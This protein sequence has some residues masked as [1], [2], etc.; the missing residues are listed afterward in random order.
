[1]LLLSMLVAAPRA[2]RAETV[3]SKAAASYRVLVFSK[4]AGE[5]VDS[6]PAGIAAIREL[7][8]QNDFAVDTTEDSG[9]FTEENLAQ[10]KAVV[11]LSV[12]GDVLNDDQQQA[13][14]GFVE[15]GGGLVA[16]NTA[17]DAE[18]DWEWYGATIGARTKSSRPA[19]Q[20]GE[21]L[22]YDPAHPSTKDLPRRVKH[23]D[24]FYNYTANVRGSLHVL[25]GVDEKSYSPGDGA[26]GYD[27]PISWCGEVRQGR[28]WYSGLGTVASAYEDAEFRKHLLG[29]IQTAAGVIES[30][31]GATVWKNF[32]TTL[33]TKDVGE[34]MDLAVL[35]DGRVLMTSRRGEFRLFDQRTGEVTMAATIDVYTGEE[36]GLQGVELDPN[37]KEN[38]W[39]YF[40][41]SPAGTTPENVLSRAKLVGDK[42]DLST[43]QK[44]LHVPTQRRLCCHVGGDIGFDAE[45][46][47]YLST[48]DNINPWQSN[49]YAPIDERPGRGDYDDQGHAANTN[50]LRGKILRIKVNEDGS[51]SIPEGNLFP[52]GTEKTKPEIYTMGER[53]PFRFDVDKKTGW[54][55][56]G[57]VGPD[58]N[59]DSPTQ[60]PEAFERLNQIRGPENHGWPYCQ[61]N[62]KP[63][64]DYDF[65]T[66]TT[67][68]PFDCDNLVNDSPNNTGLRNLPPMTS[69]LLWYPNDCATW[70]EFPQFCPPTP[71]GR[72]AMGAPVYHYDE[73][74][75]SDTKFPAY[76]DGTPFFYDYSRHR[77][78]DIKL[79][80]EGDLLNIN[81]FLPNMF[82]S[83]DGSVNGQPMDMEF[84]PDGSLYFLDYGGGF[85]TVGPRVGLYRVDY[86]KGKRSP[87]IQATATPTSGS[88]PLTV[89]FDASGTHDPD[90]DQIS[91]A[92]DFDGDGTTDSSEPV[93]EH[94]YTAKGA[95]QARLLVSDVTGKSSVQTFP[96]T[97][98]NNAPKVTISFPG[99]GGFAAFGET[100]P[101]KINVTDAED[102]EI[103]CDAVELQVAL[104]HDQHAHPILEKNGCEGTFAL[105]NVEGH[106][107]DANVFTVLRAIYTDK[108]ADGV[109]GLEG[110]HQ[111]LLQPKRKQAEHF[112]ENNGTAVI[113]H[114][115]A[116]GGRRIGAIH[117]GDWLAFNPVDLTNMTSAT[118]RVSSGGAGGTIE[119][120]K[121]SP[122][123]PLAGTA[124]VDNTGSYD[125]YVT[126][127]PVPL[128]DPGGGAD[129]LFLVFTN[130]DSSD[131]LFDVDSVRFNGK[132]MAE[133]I[134]VQVTANEKSGPAPLTVTF[135]ATAPDAPANAVYTWDFGDGG[136][137]QGA[138]VTHSYT[139]PG[140]YTAKVTV[141]DSGGGAL[142]TGTAA[143]VTVARKVEGTI[144]VTPDHVERGTGEQH[145][146]VA[147]LKPKR[148]PA[149]GH[150]MTIQVFRKAPAAPLPNG[151]TSG[152][153]Y[154]L[155][156][157]AI[158]K[159]D[160]RGRAKLAYTS[161]VGADD[162]VVACAGYQNS[163]VKDGAKV[164]VVNGKTPANL[165]TDYISDTA[166]VAWKPVP[167]SDGFV[168][169]FD[170]KT[171]GGW[172]HA[173][174]G[175]FTIN[176]GVLTPQ[177]GRG[178]LWYSRQRYR[179]FTLE[180]EY[181]Q[182]SVS[183][184]SGIFLRIPDGDAA[185][186]DP[187]TKGY[188]VSILDRVDEARFRTG[189]I[190]GIDPADFLNVKPVGGGYNKVRIEV[191]GQEYKIYWNDQLVNTY[192]GDRELAGHIGLEN[193]GGGIRFKNIRIAP[194]SK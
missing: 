93:V 121:G 110:S 189:S 71:G 120:R 141:T 69:P 64:F 38:G 167:G 126:L 191:R 113:N 137:G 157:E 30:D 59:E 10:Y 23:N 144:R 17:A 68:P 102:G 33:L 11:F 194:L 29:G 86:V 187:Q 36:D 155:A 76:Y 14:Q 160:S 46:N 182:D 45:G 78:W 163:C 75:Q 176:N 89:K 88:V 95:Y 125:R 145:T 72:T 55:Y 81:T 24:V 103:D 27:H 32:Q 133:A 41:Y 156:E 20:E 131:A 62:K 47:L 159:T 9:L 112:T 147:T 18:P 3:R 82:T 94:T 85:F 114:G 90:G 185:V 48:G 124:K 143:K 105:E 116:Q 43:E 53:N 19:A 111:I 92:W 87:V 118:F 34:P 21:L 177:G 15:R 109:P 52:P 135:T 184:D 190:D 37:F 134:G 57:V 123:G 152:T 80:D 12:T 4:T 186:A 171:L 127:D 161:P 180:L 1:M 61:A 65:A 25:A 96:I 162:I 22:V 40:Y 170:G 49:G 98:G 83:T 136:T 101:Y 130:P 67:G 44:I 91:F 73:N 146:A 79:D 181:E 7:G 140:E 154:Q 153:P 56:M 175:S 70:N 173:G 42:L 122:D 6:I 50:D 13:L 193:N 106:G 188:Q 139:K 168:D 158:T 100:V 39:V 16:L 165:R 77:A 58:A 142:G 151:Y 178:A 8:E 149:K 150:D 166:K 169:L 60:G 183:A 74:L 108:G 31:C 132:G 119:I 128:T 2:A 66:G 26:M 115:G 35:P 28:S 99:N 138:S 129:K 97:A 174:S 5:R 84:G 51:Y 148:G 107:D 63:Y 117:N 192:T 104:G 164:L 179:D 54:V 172:D